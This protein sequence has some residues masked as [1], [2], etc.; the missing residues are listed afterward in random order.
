MSWLKAQVVAVGDEEKT[1]ESTV[2]GQGWL[3]VHVH[4][5]WAPTSN[6]STR[7]SH[8]TNVKNFLY[9]YTMSS[10]LILYFS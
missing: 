3:H 6:F 1:R 4:A 7:G 9:Y 10:L 5:Q 8:F 2:E